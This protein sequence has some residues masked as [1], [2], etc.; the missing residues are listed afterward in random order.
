MAV[1][2]HKT[3]ILTSYKVFKNMLLKSD[4]SLSRCWHGK[5]CARAT[6]LCM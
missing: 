2:Q 5:L 3:I 6:C 4:I 1:Q